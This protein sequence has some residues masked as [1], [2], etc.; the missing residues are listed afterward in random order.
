[1]SPRT[2]AP[3]DSARMQAH[4]G[5]R[6]STQ[7]STSLSVLEYS[8]PKKKVVL[9]ETERWIK[10]GNKMKPFL[11]GL[12][13]F[14]ASLFSPVIACEC[15]AVSFSST[16]ETVALTLPKV[17]NILVFEFSLLRVFFVFVFLFFCFCFV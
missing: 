10:L 16:Y 15:A 7:V 2:R 1:V 4:K 5:N 8:T 13:Q 3:D 6:G 12:E 11:L 9:S 14:F 17:G